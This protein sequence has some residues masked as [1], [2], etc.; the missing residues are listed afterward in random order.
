MD[1][2]ILLL[3]GSS[4]RTSHGLGQGDTR[5]LE[6]DFISLQSHKSQAFISCHRCLEATT[7]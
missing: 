2:L 4:M 1:V 7:C 3:Q 6:N 5:L